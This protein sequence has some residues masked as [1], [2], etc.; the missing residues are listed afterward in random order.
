MLEDL[1]KDEDI[2]KDVK[3][4]TQK[5]VALKNA[6]VV[7]PYTGPAILSGRA[8][9]V[10]F[11][12]IFGH[13]VEGHRQKSEEQG[14]TF[15]KMVG[16]KILPPTMSVVFRPEEKK[17]AGNDLNSYYVYDD[18]GV[19]GS[20]VTV[21]DKGIMKNFLMNRSPIENFSHSNGH[22]RAQAG[23]KT[24][25]RQSN[26][27]VETT[28]L[29][30]DAE[31]KQML[32]D[33]CKKQGKPFGYYFADITGGFTI[34]GREIPNSFNVMPTEVYKVYV[35]GRPDELVRGVDLVGTPLAMFAQIAA[36]GGKPEVFN[37]TCGAE[38][39]GV[40]VSAVSPAIFVKQI[41]MQKKSKSQDRPPLLPRPGSKPDK[42]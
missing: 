37:G 15:K 41:E 22:G 40:P 4:M 30:T 6:P 36:A 26:L 21:V 35:D 11:H 25:S 10:F 39:G 12:E 16:E 27:I 1:P 18:E 5:L 28:D 13:R 29:K 9:G 17:M 42:D 24:V 33:E 14:Q 32:I 20:T 7:D 19:K 31:L 34:T 2:I 38:S 8:S 23:Y 3:E